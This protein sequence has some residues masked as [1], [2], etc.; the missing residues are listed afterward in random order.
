MFESRVNAPVSVWGDDD[1]DISQIY[2][3]RFG[4]F[5]G[6]KIYE[7]YG[8]Y[9]MLHFDMDFVIAANG[10]A[11]KYIPKDEIWLDRMVSKDDA[12]F[13]IIHEITEAIIMRNLGYT[14]EKAHRIAN[15]VEYQVRKRN[16]KYATPEETID[17]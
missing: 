6:F 7:V 1:L 3:R 10:Y 8:D 11:K 17:Q 12:L 5:A 13:V 14:Y 9:I 2:L 15:E 16:F 4:T